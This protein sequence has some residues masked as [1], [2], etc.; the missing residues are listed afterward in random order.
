MIFKYK[1]YNTD[2]SLNFDIN[3]E[4]N[5]NVYC[6]IG[7]N[8]AGKTNL[9]E[10]MAKS[11]I[12]SHSLF[13]NTDQHLYSKIFW[14]ES[15]QENI[16]GLK[17]FLPALIFINDTEVKKD[18][19][20]QLTSFEN[21][22]NYNLQFVFDKPVIFIGANNRGYTKNIDRKHIK[23]LGNYADS[24][25]EAFL[26]TYNYINGNTVEDT[27]LAE[28][29][30]SRL[31]INPSFVESTDDRT[32]EVN[33]CLALIDK[34]ETNSDQKIRDLSEKEY[35]F[36]FSQGLLW[37]NNIPVNKLST[38]Y[39]SIL[40]IFQDIINN[41]SAWIRLQ[42]SDLKEHN[43][44]D[45]EAIVFID[46][47]ESHLHPKWQHKFIPLLKEFFPK[48]TFYIAT[49]SPVIISTTNEGEAYELVRDDFDVTAKKL[50]NPKEWYLA[51]IFSQAFHVN[52]NKSISLSDTNDYSISHLLKKFS[53]LVKNYAVNQDDRLKNEVEELYQK[54]LPNLSSDDP[55]RRSLDSLRSLVNESN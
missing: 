26:K 52:L 55:R 3:L 9:F 11:L 46:E 10:N 1:A 18:D 40:K 14:K 4:K 25:N 37:L 16:K 13:K 27:D 2:A 12:F 30:S 38:G 41:F 7:E 44:N 28:W 51:D 43:L 17:L 8:A 53:I 35:C 42:N 32:S 23:V 39:I 19:S 47:L 6:F 48:I 54:I 22:I 5:K 24:F 20:W 50:G 45:F 21:I 36:S 33:H 49:H 15:I 31:I 29:I 34:L